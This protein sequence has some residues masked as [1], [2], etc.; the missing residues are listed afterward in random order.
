MGTYAPAAKQ[1]VALVGGKDNVASLTHCITRLRFQLKDESIADTAA[2]EA[3]PEV[4]TV[5]RSGGQY[6]VVIGNQVADVYAEVMPLLPQLSDEDSPADTAPADGNLLHRFVDIV[7]GIFQPILGLMAACGMIKGLNLLFSHLGWYADTS[8]AYQI[9]NAV[10]DGMFFFLPV[11]LGFT[12]AKKFGLKPMLGLAVGVSM[13]YPAIQASSL[14]GEREAIRT[15]FAGTDFAADV[16]LDFFGIPVIAMDY[17]ST[18]I[19]VIFVV[20]VAAKLAR[21]F[22][23]YVPDLVKFFFSPMLTLL[24]AVPLGFL[25]IGPVASFGANAIAS[26]V[27][28]LR[29]FSPLLAGLVVGA[30]WQILVIFGLHWG[31]IPVYINNIVVNGYDNVMMPFFACTFATSAVVL[32]VFFKT[33]DDTIKKLCMPNFISGIF[34]VTEPA[35][36]GI[37]LP[38]KTPFVISCIAGGIGGAFYG[39]MNFRK[40]I[41]GGMGIFEFPGMINPDGTNGNIIVAVSGVVITMIVAFVLTMV[42]YRPAASAA[43][44]SE[45]STVAMPQSASAPAEVQHGTA[46]VADGTTGATQVATKQ[47]VATKP[48]VASKPTV[49]TTT[50]ASP[51]AGEVFAL[52]ALS[53]PV[54]ASGKLGAGVAIRPTD[55]TVVSPVDGTVSALFPTGH[56]IGITADSGAELLIHIGLDTVELRGDG[57]H[58]L[59]AKGDRVTLGQRLIEVDLQLL[60]KRG[61]SSDTPVVVVNHQRFTAVT[62]QVT[63]GATVTPGQ[64][65]LHAASTFAE[66]SAPENTGS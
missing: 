15:V 16:Y 39:A 54:F 45:A 62:E 46:A 20:W 19:P 4:V 1:I 36:Y 41:M 64:A 56:A 33:K 51:L 31:F 3:L 65:L 58:P 32:A 48:T 44:T 35:I 6:Q 21:F 22:D 5:M 26:T 66:A 60:A 57:F 7:S 27:I 10:G 2:L 40:F 24:V 17:T 30:T 14:S 38:L 63:S 49:T 23:R 12:A 55:G 50:I 47:T 13:L 29:D 52:T 59:V 61:Y 43:T 42:F 9:F 34:G 11:F 25:L 53:D 8:G 18:V 37:L 28:A